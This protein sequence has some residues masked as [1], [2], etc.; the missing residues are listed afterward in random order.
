[1]SVRVERYSGTR[2]D[3]DSFVRSRPDW[4]HFHLHGWRAVMER[5][6]GHECVYLAARDARD[7]LCGV[8]PLVRVRSR[9]FGHYLVSMP[10]VN[11]GGPLGDAVA[12]AALAE[13][14]VSLARTDGVKL[15]ELRSRSELPI[16]LPASHRKITVVLDLPKADPNLLWKK[17]DAKLR[18]QIRRPQKDG[19][20]LRFGHEEITPF[21]SVF[22]RHMRDLGTPTQPKRLFE[23]IAE[24]FGDDVWF[25]CAYHE[26]KAVAC[27]CGFRWGNEFEI[28]WASALIEHKRL[29][30][31]MLVYWGLME[32]AIAEGVA[33]FNFGRCTPG[34]GTHRFKQ[35]WGSRDEMLWWYHWSAAGD[36]ATPSPNDG[37]YSWGPRIWKRLPEAIATSIG[38][39][40]VRYIP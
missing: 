14:A 1:M 10:F 28:T 16:A 7:R 19:V 29:S 11:Y 36:A 20:T 2:E 13:A 24:E 38:P 37:A 32:R 6:Y 23:V 40:I 22:A 39:R 34:S 5:V 8:L 35:Q 18:S 33:V 26:G 31:N 9:L 25:A 15:L 12:V 4:T 27:G 21:Y 3:W 30:A 17:L